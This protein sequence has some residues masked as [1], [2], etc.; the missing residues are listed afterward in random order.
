MNQIPWTMKSSGVAQFGKG[1]A[2]DWHLV[3][4]WLTALSINLVCVMETAAS[5]TAGAHALSYYPNGSEFLLFAPPI[6]TQA[7][8]STIL[9]WVARGA[10]ASF[11]PATVPT[12][13]KGNSYSGLGVHS[14][15][16]LFGDSGEALYVSSSSVGGDGHVVTTRMPSYDEATLAVVEVKNGGVVQDVQWNKVLSPPATSLSVTTTGAATLVAVWAGAFYV[17][18]SAVPDNGFKNVE[19]LFLPTVSSYIQAAVAT[20]DV[21]GPGTYNVTWSATPE[22]GA[23]LWL[24]AVQNVPPPILKAKRTGGNLVISWPTS[25]VRYALEMTSEPSAAAGAWTSVTNPPV[26]VEGQNTI[27][28]AIAPGNLF[29]RLRKG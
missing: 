25:T 17:A 10:M 16:P 8:G 23:N 20:K 2:R 11:T 5:P 26:M 7:S 19:E 12:D 14:Y 28:N 6:V 1:I 13:N 4:V 29:Y 27:T 21:A 18:R 9:V 3:M 15:A 24:V 22:Q